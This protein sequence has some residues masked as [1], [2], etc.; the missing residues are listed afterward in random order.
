M[1]RAVGAVIVKDLRILS[2]GYNGTP[3][4]TKNCYEYGCDRCN[5]NAKQG[6]GLGECMCIHAEEGA[7]IEAGIF[8][9]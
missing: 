5:S 9:I 3:F 6:S 7:V 8:Y 1:K 4:D 2:T